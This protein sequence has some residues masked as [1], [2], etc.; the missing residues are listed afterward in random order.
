M[1]L[2]IRTKITLIALAILC[3]TLAA[4]T[5]T[6]SYMSMREYTKVLQSESIVIAQSLKLQLDRVLKLKI[7]I[8]ELVGFEEQCNELVHKY[9]LL[10]YAM[11]VD[12]NGKVLF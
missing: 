7:P 1:V 3:L 8:E 5:V 12:L 9:E 2:N 4:T 6:N 10:S 11:V